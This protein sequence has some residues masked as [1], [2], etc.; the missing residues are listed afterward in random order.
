MN[1]SDYINKLDTIKMKSY[2]EQLMKD[3]K[4][5]FKG[6]T[7]A[8]NSRN[9]IKHISSNRQMNN[10]VNFVLIPNNT[11][12]MNDENNEMSEYVGLSSF[13]KSIKYLLKDLVSVKRTNSIFSNMNEK[14]W[15]TFANKVWESI[16]KS[17]IISEYYRLMT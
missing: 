5:K 1:K 7:T 16:K 14:K 15:F 3:S 4:L 9:N 12:N 6:S 10:Q 11:N 2:L 8:T 17:P 13:D